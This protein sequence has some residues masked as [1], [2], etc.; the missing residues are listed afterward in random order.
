M[1]K[2]LNFL[3]LLFRAREHQLPCRIAAECKPN[4]D[5]GL[6]AQALIRRARRVADAFLTGAHLT[7][8]PK[9]P[10]MFARKTADTPAV[11]L[12]VE[13]VTATISKSDI[14]RVDLKKYLATFCA[15]NGLEII[16]D[17]SAQ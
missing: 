17:K 8:A 12:C 15:G 4:A 5:T 16:I 1:K 14:I 9:S 2:K 3:L 13:S 7:S 10:Q 6:L 11:H